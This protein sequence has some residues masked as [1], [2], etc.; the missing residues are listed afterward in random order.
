[1]HIYLPGTNQ[2]DATDMIVLL[3]V[4]VIFAV[5]GMTILFAADTFIFINFT[6]IPMFST[7][8]QRQ[9]DDF[10]NDL[11]DK[12]NTGDVKQIKKQ[13]IEIIQMQSKYNEYK[14]YIIELD[15]LDDYRLSFILSET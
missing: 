14:Y 2:L 3:I 6:T 5:I 11:Q 7:I 1:M 4:N 13:L 9:I 15:I 8:V 10:K 12:K